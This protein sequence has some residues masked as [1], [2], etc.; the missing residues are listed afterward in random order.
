M[1]SRSFPDYHSLPVLSTGKAP[2]ELQPGGQGS[3][4]FFVG[5]LK[6]LQG[7]QRYTHLYVDFENVNGLPGI[8]FKFQPQK[9]RWMDHVE[10][11]KKNIS[12][13]LWG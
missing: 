5:F 7:A 1:L 3:I 10:E 2:N 8:S 4:E 12:S 6:F 11:K 9:R 13:K